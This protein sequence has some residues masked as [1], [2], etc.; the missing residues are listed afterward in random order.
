MLPASA[1]TFAVDGAGRSR[2]LRYDARRDEILD[3]AVAAFRKK[4]YAGTSMRDIGRA[5]MRTQ[6][7]LYYYFPDKEA[8]LYRSHERALDRV[9]EMAA[10]VRRRTPDPAERLRGLIEG[11]V[12]LM[13][14]EFHGTAFALELGALSGSRLRAVVRR[15]DRY[16]RILRGVIAAGIRRG[17]F[18]PADPKLT[19]F[20]LLGSINWIARW[21]R[22]RGGAG[23]GEVG[24]TFADL[25]LRSLLR[26]P[27]R[28]RPAPTARGRRI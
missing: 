3:I 16:E 2:R 23:I 28:S 7:S 15:R 9:L 12:A 5:L 26:N 6:G 24:R 4:G 20:A 19:A 14:Q 22:P 27:T 10:E 1:R 18:H 17:Q 11:H 25:Y 21:Y 13:V 8:I